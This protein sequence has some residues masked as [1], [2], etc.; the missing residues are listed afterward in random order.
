[1]PVRAPKPLAIRRQGEVFKF[2]LRNQHALHSR[3]PLLG[4]GRLR[5]DSIPDHYQAQQDREREGRNPPERAQPRRFVLWNRLAGSSPSVDLARESIN[6]AS[7]L[8]RM[9]VDRQSFFLLPPP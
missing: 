4:R 1:V 3:F 9:A 6:T 7:T 2:A 8:V 5:P